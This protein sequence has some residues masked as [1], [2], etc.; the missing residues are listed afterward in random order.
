MCVRRSCEAVF[1][2]C[3]VCQETTMRLLDIQIELSQ[4]QLRVQRSFLIPLF[5]SVSHHVQMLSSNSGWLDLNNDK[6]GLETMGIVDPLSV[7]LHHMWACAALIQLL[8]SSGINPSVA[9][10]WTA[11]LRFMK[12]YAMWCLCQTLSSF[13]LREKDISGHRN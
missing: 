11:E 13:C 3:W 10:V 2:S 7:P 4:V 8:Y 5:T 9:A 12:C 6:N 1:V